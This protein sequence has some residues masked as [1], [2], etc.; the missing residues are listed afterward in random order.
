MRQRLKELSPDERYLRSLRICEKLRSCFSGRKSVALF[1]PKLTEPDLDLCWDLN[2]LRDLLVS[3]PRCHGEA[4]SFH[5][6]SALSELLP[7]PFGIREPQA[8]PTP[9]QLDIIVVPGLAFTAAGHR[10]GRGAGFYDKFLSAV[11]PGTIKIGACFNFQLLADIPQE[12]HD[13]L[14]DFVVS[15]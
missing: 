8:G 9:E 1:A 10:L 11:P 4:L 13:A 15:G 2:L 14:V 12:S 6:V 3:Y 5:V 7:G